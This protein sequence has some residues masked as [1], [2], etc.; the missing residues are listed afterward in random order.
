DVVLQRVAEQATVITGARAC[1]IRLLSESGELPIIAAHGLSEAYLHKGQVDLA[2]SPVDRQ[3]LLGEA[4]YIEDVAQSTLLQYPDELA[5][6]GI[7]SLLCVPLRAQDEA[8][9][10]IRV[11]GANTRAFDQED[12]RF[13]EYFASL[14]AMAIRNAR[15]WRTIQE[16]DRERARFTRTV[17]HELRS[18]LAAILGNLRI[19]CQGYA[20]PVP[21]R[22][23]QLLERAHHRGTLLLALAGDLLALVSGRE[24]PNAATEERVSLADIVS[25]V[26]V[27]VEQEVTLKALDLRLEIGETRGEVQGRRDQLTRMVE[28][29]VSNAVKYTPD[30]GRITVSLREQGKA[31]ELVVQ[32]TG[33]GIPKDQQAHL[34][35]EFFRA[36]N[37]R[38]LTDNGTG[39]GLAIVKRMV[40]NHH[41]TIAI[42]SEEG[43]G[44]RVTV[45]LPAAR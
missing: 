6:E 38:Q 40:E 10:V 44:T 1:S 25:Q 26:A 13:L 2:R 32:D 16:T 37:A 23:L 43:Q 30:G 19:I 29:L 8:L 27:D 34:F 31:V 36:E 45:V 24:A 41:G 3:A 14:A 35:E 17:A 11:Y 15:S 7:R 28:N 12:Q 4:V 39:L 18:P 22:V 9:G 33:I 20:G 42:E 5:R 21:D